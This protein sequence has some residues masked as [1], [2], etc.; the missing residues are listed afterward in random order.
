MNEVLKGVEEKI[1]KRNNPDTTH[2]QRQERNF[3]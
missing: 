1:K 3:N 2:N